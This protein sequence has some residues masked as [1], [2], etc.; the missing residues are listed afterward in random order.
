MYIPS[1]KKHKVRL[2]DFSGGI[3]SSVDEKL[4]KKGASVS[5][6]F[7]FK[8]G[9][10]K[11][12]EGFKALSVAG[13]PCLLDGAAPQKIYYYRRYDPEND[14][15]DDR[16]LVYADDGYIYGRKADAADDFEKID[17]L[18]F[19]SAPEGVCYKL[20]GK[21]VMLFSSEDRIYVY[22]C[23]AVSFSSYPAPEI[24]SMCVCNERL[25][26]TTGGESTTLWFSENFDPTNWYVSLS[27]AGFIDFQDG[28]GKLLKVVE[29]NGYVYIFRSY[30]ITRVYAPYLQSEFST[31]NIEADSVRII[32]K[33]V[34]DCGKKIVYMTE[35]GFFSFDGEYS[36]RILKKLDAYILGVD[37]ESVV[38]AFYNGRYYAKILVNI[39]GK[40]ESVVLS[41][42]VTDGDFYLIR[43]ANVID[44]LTVLSDEKAKL[45]ALVDGSGCV[46]EL[47]GSP[48]CLEKKLK[49][50]W[51]SP[52]TDFNVEGLKTLGSVSLYTKGDVRLSFESER[53]EK[54]VTVYGGKGIKRETVGLKGEDFSVTITSDTEGANVSNLT[55]EFLKV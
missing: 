25:F 38:S 54:C 17:D 18:H 37:N 31:T 41:Y 52:F 24:T 42:D 33:S 34:V 28:K 12:G 32:G 16:I 13:G 6:N 11:D 14:V 26:V 53:G 7:S 47:T 48:V 2:F 1:V 8:N 43:G 51:R 22:D 50:I 44:M 40:I 29:H 20:N 55:L 21:D 45:F 30:G 3:D 39:G 46:C 15:R 10:L 36:V 19:D 4:N 35:N 23:D 27:E 5:F 9:A 49:K